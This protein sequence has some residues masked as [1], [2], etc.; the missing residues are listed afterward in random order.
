MWTDYIASAREKANQA[1]GAKRDETQRDEN[2]PRV[3]TDGHNM[4]SILS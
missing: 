2:D 3:H 1:S 4:I